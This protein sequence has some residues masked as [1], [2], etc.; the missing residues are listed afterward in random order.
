MFARRLI[1]AV[2]RRSGERSIVA[3]ATTIDRG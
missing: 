2:T 1:S 3:N